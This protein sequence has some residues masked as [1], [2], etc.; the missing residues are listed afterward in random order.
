MDTILTT[1]GRKQLAQGQLKA[2]FYSFS[3]YAAI[4]KTDTILSGGLLDS[5]RIIL[6]A[7][8]LPQ[9]TIIFETDDSGKLSSLPVSGSSQ[10]TVLQGQIFSGSSLISEDVFNGVSKELLNQSINAFK[11]QMIL[12]SPDLLDDR[13]REF[14]VS[15]TFVSYSITESYPFKKEQISEANINHIESLFFDK[16][17]AH[18]KNFQFLPPKNK[19][20]IGES[21][22]ASLGNFINI[23]QKP[24]NT[25]EELNDDLKGFE[26]K[27]IYFTETSTQ[28]NL[29]CQFFEVGGNVMSKL[30]VIDFGTFQ[31]KDSI[32]PVH[33]FY[34][35][36]VFTDDFGA[37]TFVNMF[38]LVFE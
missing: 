38:T 33:V 24:I 21:E 32:L 23:S 14:I 35:G 10:Y 30:D 2:K 34:V 8:S 28:N 22:G 19:P 15:P 29:F 20:R 25:I 16:R 13:K 1:E 7:T 12:K 27:T 9:D 3:D 17:L 31:N 4:Y 37:H 26:K 5:H 18:L 36:K 6:E 11:N